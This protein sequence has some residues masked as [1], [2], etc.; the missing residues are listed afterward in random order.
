GKGLLGDPGAMFVIPPRATC[1]APARL[2][3]SCQDTWFDLASR[4]ERF[5]SH[6]PS[7]VL[8][9][10]RLLPSTASIPSAKELVAPKG[11][12]PVAR[13]EQTSALITRTVG[14]PSRV[15][16]GRQEPFSV[17]DIQGRGSSPRLKP[18]AFAAL[19]RGNLSPG[20]CPGMICY[21]PDGAKSRI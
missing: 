2:P 6:G 9:R 17:L 11:S 10:P 3:G 1:V 13:F 12:S 18:G 14:Q 7:D 20:R 4:D 15:G 8:R 21:G 19:T 16:P 5:G